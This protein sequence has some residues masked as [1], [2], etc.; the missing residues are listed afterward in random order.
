[1]QI[2]QWQRH[3][4]EKEGSGSK[5]RSQASQQR[6]GLGNPETERLGLP[7]QL[8]GP[9]AASSGGGARHHAS[10][11]PAAKLATGLVAQ[12]DTRPLAQVA[13]KK[14]K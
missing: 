3:G 12:P 10:Y 5:R 8:E 2:Q 4:L 9:F 11:D 14:T 13:A 1:M 6:P 7:A